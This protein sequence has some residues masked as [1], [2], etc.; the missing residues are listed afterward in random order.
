MIMGVRLTVH[1]KRV[2]GRRH[3]QI[4]IIRSRLRKPRRSSMEVRGNRRK[5]TL[6]AR[7]DSTAI[8]LVN[9]FEKWSTARIKM[10]LANAGLPSGDSSRN[11]LFIS[12]DDYFES[13]DPA[14]FLI[15]KIGKLG[16]DGFEFA[17]EYGERASDIRP[18]WETLKVDAAAGGA[19]KYPTEPL[20]RGMWTT[21]FFP[22]L[23]LLSYG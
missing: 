12:L 13:S 8:A 15:K 19:K 20:R 22:R 4:I 18:A 11:L 17:R 7:Y 6:T 3:R 1:A 9:E 23:M 21:S 14:G 16:P 10:L 5:H 2:W